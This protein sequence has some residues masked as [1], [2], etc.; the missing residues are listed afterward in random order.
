M[1]G[2]HYSYDIHINLKMSVEQI[3]CKPTITAWLHPTRL[4]LNLKKQE[5]VINLP[6]DYESLCRHMEQR[7]TQNIQTENKTHLI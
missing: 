3:A 5:Y 1:Y 4:S 7:E 6:F 2:Y